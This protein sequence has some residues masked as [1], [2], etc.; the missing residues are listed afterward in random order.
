MAISPSTTTATKTN[1]PLKN[2]P[3]SVSITTKEQADDQGSKSLGQALSYVP[4]VNVAQGEGHRDQVT[5]RGQATTSDFYVDGVRDDVEYYRDLYNVEAIEVVKGP[6]AM[7]FGRGG[8]GGV[9]NRSTK[10][11]DGETIREGTVTYGMFDTANS[12]R[13]RSGDHQFSSIPPQRDVRE[14]RKPSRFLRTRT[15]WHQSDLGIQA[16]RSDQAVDELRVLQ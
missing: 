10:Q 7:I 15:L 12:R 5:I 13:C 2:V 1:T 8:S 4:G 11:A 6:N 3:Q 9:V 16:V 14:F